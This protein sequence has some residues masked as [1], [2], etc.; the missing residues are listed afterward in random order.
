MIKNIE[1]TRDGMGSL[2]DRTHDAVV[3][4]TDRAERGV[5]SAAERVVERTHAAG[6][7]IR[8]G[9]KTVSR[10]AHVRVN[11]AARTIERGYARASSD[12]SRAVSAGSDYVAANPGK[13]LLLT[14]SAGFVLGLLVRRRR[15]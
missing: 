8:D 2:I 13:A 3:S 15:S 9:A 11:G 1:R 7:A 14:L 12:V 4:A 5:E 6:D 10:D